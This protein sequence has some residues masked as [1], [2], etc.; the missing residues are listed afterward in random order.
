M[1]LNKKKLEN[2][3]KNMQ[4]QNDLKHKLREKLFHQMLLKFF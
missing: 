2:Y 3:I 4:I 1:Y